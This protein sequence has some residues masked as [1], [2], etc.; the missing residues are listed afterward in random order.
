MGYLPT[1][2]T[3]I[4]PIDTSAVQHRSQPHRF[5]GVGGGHVLTSVACASTIAIRFPIHAMQGT[6]IELPSAL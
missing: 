5:V 3:V 1:P 4:R 6:A 2:S